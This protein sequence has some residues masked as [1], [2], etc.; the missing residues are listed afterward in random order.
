M[1]VA[2]VQSRTWRRWSEVLGPERVARTLDEHARATGSPRRLAGTFVASAVVTAYARL[3]GRS[4]TLA[5]RA[6]TAAPEALWIEVVDG[7]VGSHITVEPHDVTDHRDGPVELL[8]SAALDRLLDECL[9]AVAGQGRVSGRLLATDAALAWLAGIRAALAV[10][11]IQAHPA[12]L[13]AA[14]WRCGRELGGLV[15]RHAVADA[16]GASLPYLVRRVCCLE[17]RIDTDEDQV[18]CATCPLI[19]LDVVLRRRERVVQ[20]EKPPPFGRHDRRGRTTGAP[21]AGRPS[22]TDRS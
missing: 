6:I 3:Q 2:G 17:Y 21:T 10:R 19:P 11:P 5:G 18:F 14:Q 13:L 15:E 1:T 20:G 8:A 7:A 22:I 12:D 9:A 4:L 16:H